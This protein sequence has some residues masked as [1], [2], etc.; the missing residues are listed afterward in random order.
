MKKIDIRDFMNYHYPTGLTAAPDGKHGVFAVVDVNEKENCYDSCLWTM[1]LS[2]GS[3]RKL[4]SG[5][6]ERNFSWIDGKTL[7]FAG[8]R[9]KEYKDKTNGNIA[10]F[11]YS[12]SW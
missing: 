10:A 12:F 2:D 1:D 4:T 7:L 8:C 5:R 9:E 11:D 3:V 6:K